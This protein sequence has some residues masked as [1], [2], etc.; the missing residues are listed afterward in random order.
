[1]KQGT[2]DRIAYKHFLPKIL[3]A[4]AE[5]SKFN[6]VDGFGLLWAVMTAAAFLAAY[7]AEPQPHVD[8][9]NPAAGADG[10]ALVQWKYDKSQF[11]IQ[12]AALEA[13][14]ALWLSSIFPHLLKP[15]EVGRSLRTRTLVH[16]VTTLSAQLAVFK[17]EDFDWLNREL[18]VPY[19]IGNDV[20]SFLAQKQE[21][22]LD[23]AEAGQ[24]VN[25]MDAVALLQSLFPPRAYQLCWQEYAKEHG[26]IAGRTPANLSAF[27]IEYA[28]QRLQHAV[29]YS[30]LVAEE[31]PHIGAPPVA[32]AAIVAAPTAAEPE[33]VAFLALM[34]KDAP[35]A[36]AYLRGKSVPAA[37]P[38]AAPAAVPAAA[39]K[40][41]YCHTCGVPRNKTLRHHS[42][43]CKNK[44]PGHRNDATFE[45]QLGGK[46][47]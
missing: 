44:A 33:L 37:A 24:P 30:A 38:A 47:A 7:G 41:F 40:R 20:P 25:N 34:A 26:H 32:A 16:M 13:L 19:K 39:V 36:A 22:L 17:Q 8:P 10:A 14:R 2:T 3:D 45:K 29:G 6:S 42:T 18:R 23:L 46:S 43:D 35:A 27:I 5:A 15:M 9:E 12:G 21:Y 31:L 1:M 4:A 28:D 11:T